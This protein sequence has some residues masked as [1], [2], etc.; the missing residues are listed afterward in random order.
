MGTM[1][2]F[3]D[4]IILK[5]KEE[6]TQFGGE[7][8]KQYGQRYK[9]APAGE[10]SASSDAARSYSKGGKDHDALSRLVG[11]HRKKHKK[12]KK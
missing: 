3:N 12:K 8:P 2:T 9:V 1:I 11:A 6:R 5:E 7:Y 10:T 4:W